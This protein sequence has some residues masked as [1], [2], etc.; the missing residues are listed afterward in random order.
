[1]DIQVLIED[2]YEW[3]KQLV[4]Y[5]RFVYYYPIQDV[6]DLTHDI[7]LVLLEENVVDKEE[8]G[9]VIH[10]VLDKHTKRRK[11]N[12]EKVRIPAFVL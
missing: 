6:E 10:R 5:K 7:I 2:N 1:M 8:W 11:R 9:R 4:L 12:K 3:L